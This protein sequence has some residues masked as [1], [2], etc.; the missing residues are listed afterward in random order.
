MKLE[1]SDAEYHYLL[2][3][4]NMGVTVYDLI[5]DNID[6]DF[7]KERDWGEKVI[8]KVLSYCTDKRI[9]TEC[10]WMNV[11]QDTQIRKIID[12]LWIYEDFVIDEYLYEYSK[13]DIL[14]RRQQSFELFDWDEEDR[15]DLKDF[16]NNLFNKDQK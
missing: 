10:E 5:H 7:V 9:K 1:L 4:L 12:D 3:F 16:F 2:K 13:E 15:Q 14:E 6:R 8:D 11:F